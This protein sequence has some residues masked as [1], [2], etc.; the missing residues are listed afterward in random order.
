M[1]MDILAVVI[2]TAIVAVISAAVA[3][4]SGN[5]SGRGG[6]AGNRQSG[7]YAGGQ[8]PAA[9]ISDALRE[10][11]VPQ[12]TGPMVYFANDRHGSRDKEFQFNYKKVNGEWRAY[13]LRMPG[14]GGR[15]S[16][17]AATHRHFDGGR[18]YICWDTPVR[19]LKDM[20]NISKVWADNILEY[21]VTGRRF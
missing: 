21:I 8:M 9:P 4:H 19:N 2:I 16:G 6:N 7:G 3:G 17:A 13:I 18:P 5:R 10:R 20:Q 14:L 1:V 12:E 11:R 15:D